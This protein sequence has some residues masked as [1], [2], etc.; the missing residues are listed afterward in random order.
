MLLHRRIF[1]F[2]QVKIVQKQVTFSVD[3]SIVKVLFLVFFGFFLQDIRQ[4]LVDS[5]FRLICR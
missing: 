5:E 4:V 2:F 1:L 3:V